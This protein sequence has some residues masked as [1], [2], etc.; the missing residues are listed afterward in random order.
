MDGLIANHVLTGDNR[1]RRVMTTKSMRDAS[2]EELLSRARNGTP[3]AM[4]ELLTR[5]QGQLHGYA[6]RLAASQPDGARPSDFIQN[7]ALRAMVRWETFRGAT[8]AEWV[9]WLRQ[10]LQREVLM[11]ARRAGR[12]KRR[13]GPPVG[14]DEPEAQNVRDSGLTPSKVASQLEDW[15]KVLSGL[16]ELPETQKEAIKLCYL[17]ELPVA[18]AARALQRSEAAVASLLQRGL[19]ALREQ[20][21]GQPT[22]GAATTRSAASRQSRALLEYLRRRD[23]G[24]SI[25]PE[26]FVAE[27][28]ESAAELRA[29]L[30]SIAAIQAVRPQHK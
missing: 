12:L 22:P 21:M 3:G 24:E 13:S 5:Y 30:R 18:E 23:L 7:M 28:P 29:M 2:F 25:D 16:H 10:I 27:Y 4:D 19:R 8:E 1:A 14:L 20:I 26:A 15:H 17:E 6:H 11:V 9:A